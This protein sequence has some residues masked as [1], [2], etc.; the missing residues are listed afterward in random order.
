MELVDRDISTATVN[1][2]HLFKK[3][4]ESKGMLRR[5]IENTKRPI[6]N[7]DR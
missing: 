3:I 7:F 1:I 6:L 5:Q 2:L 4:E